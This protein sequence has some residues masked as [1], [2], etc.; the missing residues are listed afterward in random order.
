[1]I[2]GRTSHQL[3]NQVRFFVKEISELLPEDV[4]CSVDGFHITLEEVG[5]DLE[6]VLIHA[7]KVNQKV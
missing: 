5:I 7:R 3:A 4:I 1:M 2:I 6:V